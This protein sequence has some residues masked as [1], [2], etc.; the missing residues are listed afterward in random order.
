MTELAGMVP[1]IFGGRKF[2]LSLHFLALGEV[3]VTPDSTLR[4][5]AAGRDEVDSSIEPRFIVVE[6]LHRMLSPCTRKQDTLLVVVIAPPA[7]PRL[8]RNVDIGTGMPSKLDF[9]GVRTAYIARWSTFLCIKR[10]LISG[11][12][13]GRTP[14]GSQGTLFLGIGI[15][16]KRHPQ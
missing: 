9:P 5:P 6:Q 11:G 8:A 2:R 13:R 3:H 7:L 1:V 4:H 16:A 12:A 14:S 10:L 15:S